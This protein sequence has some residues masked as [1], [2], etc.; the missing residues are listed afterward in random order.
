MSG[1]ITIKKSTYTRMIFGI[2]AALV[3]AA[4]LGGILVGNLGETKTGQNTQ[5][6][7]AQIPTTP[8][9]ARLQSLQVI[10]PYWEAQ[11]PQLQ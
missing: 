8:T 6:I 9:P 4:F 11:V 5:I 10:V 3:V 2:T 7:P 1:D